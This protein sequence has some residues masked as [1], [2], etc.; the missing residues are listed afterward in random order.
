MDVITYSWWNHVSKMGP[1]KVYYLSM[2]V[3]R[4]T[5]YDM[6]LQMAKAKPTYQ[7]LFYK[8]R[9]ILKDRIKK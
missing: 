3:Y 8:Q 4:I 5:L 6:L 9:N 7:I 1:W 2:Q